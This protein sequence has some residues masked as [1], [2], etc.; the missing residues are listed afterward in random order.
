MLMRSA[1][2]LQAQAC[3]SQRTHGSRWPNDGVAYKLAYYSVD[4]AHVSYNHGHQIRPNCHPLVSC[5]NVFAVYRRSKAIRTN[6]A[7]RQTCGVWTLDVW[8]SG[9]YNRVPRDL[10]QCQ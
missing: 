3:D 1:G 2:S 9:V 4:R 7:H 10:P 5:I 8:R 6:L